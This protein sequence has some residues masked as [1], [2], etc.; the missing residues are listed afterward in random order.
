MEKQIE[1]PAIGEILK[2]EFLEPMGISAYSL[3]KHINVPSSRI[4]DILHGKRRISIETGLKLS[5]YFDLSDRFFIN[6][7]TDID[8][9]NRKNS[10]T[11]EL[12]KIEPI[13]VRLRA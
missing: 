5:R 1:T 9:R 7:Q 2:E 12:T 13:N 6:L 3:A 4:L 10:L 11:T 8:V